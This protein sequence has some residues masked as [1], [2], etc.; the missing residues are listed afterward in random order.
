[1]WAGCKE[2]TRK[3]KTTK[4][5]QGIPQH[6]GTLCPPRPIEE[7]EWVVNRVGLE[8]VWG[9]PSE[10][11]SD[12]GPR[13]IGSGRPRWRFLALQRTLVSSSHNFR[14][15]WNFQSFSC[16]FTLQPD[17]SIRNEVSSL[18]PLNLS[19]P[20]NA[21]RIKLRLHSL[22]H[23][24]LHD[25]VPL[26]ATSFSSCSLPLQ[27]QP[28]RTS[29]RS[30]KGP[31]FLLCPG[32]STCCS[33]C[34]EGCLSQTTPTPLPPFLLIL[35]GLAITANQKTPWIL[36][37]WIK[38]PGLNHREPVSP[39]NLQ[40]HESFFFPGGIKEGV[41]M[42]EYSSHS[43]SSL[44]RV[45]FSLLKLQPWELGTIISV[46]INHLVHGTLC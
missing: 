3:K 31:C 21:L 18:F 24:V 36:Q 25:L 43:F 45:L 6:P 22:A 16:L 38:E 34:P 14:E 28:C 33:S 20:L 35:W 10:R 11:S 44:Q 12:P 13:T 37:N 1:M 42:P 41:G 2:T 9:G 27:I 23:K 26:P 32:V 40:A 30:S 46:V 8:A 4:K 15:G 29:C 7:R 19:I 17:G 5:L 39:L